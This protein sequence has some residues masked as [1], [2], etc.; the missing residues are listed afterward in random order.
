MHTRCTDPESPE[1]PAHTVFHYIHTGTRYLLE[2]E[3]M[4]ACYI[5]IEP[6]EHTDASHVVVHCKHTGT[7]YLSESDKLA[8]MLH[9]LFQ[10][11][12]SQNDLPDLDSLV[13]IKNCDTNR[14]RTVASV[15]AGASTRQF[16]SFDRHVPPELLLRGPTSHLSFGASEVTLFP[17]LYFL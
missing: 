15:S 4:H 6:F 14:V 17:L 1:H 8:H 10:K 12:V 11:S 9:Q 3:N 5:C 13:Q 7:R 16:R 2:S